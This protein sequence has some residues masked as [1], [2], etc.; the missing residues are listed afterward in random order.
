MQQICD[1]KLPLWTIGKSKNP[2]CFKRVQWDTLGS[3]WR[4]NKKAWM[5]TP[6]MKE[7]L[8]WFQ[9]CMRLKNKF[10]ILLLDNF[11]A[12]DKAVFELTQEGKLSN[13]EVCFLPKNMISKWQPCDQGI[14]VALKLHYKQCQDLVTN[15]PVS[16]FHCL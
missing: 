3:E 4:S 14:I 5:N 10:V 16:L 15:R 13:V 11:S 2:H 7:W 9:A 6:L 1:D 8:L 12:H